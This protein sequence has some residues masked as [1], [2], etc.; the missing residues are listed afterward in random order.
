MQRLQEYELMDELLAQDNNT[1]SVQNDWEADQAVRRIVNARRERD[2][3]TAHHRAQIEHANE[4]C[5]YTET[6]YLGAL[7]KYFESLPVRQTKTQASYPL[8]SGQLILKLPA[9]SYKVDDV[10]FSQWLEGSKY[11]QFVRSEV[12]KRPMWGEFKKQTKVVDGA[13]VDAESGEIVHGVEVKMNPATFA[14]KEA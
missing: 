4:R 3:L 8:P 12:V 5:E 13:L 11:G 1:Y 14:I 7:E 9:P 6:F 2:R 10:E